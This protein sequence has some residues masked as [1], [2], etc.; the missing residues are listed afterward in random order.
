M[1]I[2]A[3]MSMQKAKPSSTLTKVSPRGPFTRSGLRWTPRKGMDSL[4]ASARAP[5]LSGPRGE[6]ECACLPGRARCLPHGRRWVTEPPSSSPPSVTAQRPPRPGP[7]SLLPWFPGE[8]VSRGASGH[9]H[10]A[11]VV[12]DLPEKTLDHRASRLDDAGTV[13]LESG[14]RHP[15]ENVC[16][17]TLASDSSL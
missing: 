11:R 4:G 12:R 13:L 8:P 3:G 10:W 7:G 15:H 14:S 16:N 6:A 2:L 5:K 9:F 17:Q 1:R